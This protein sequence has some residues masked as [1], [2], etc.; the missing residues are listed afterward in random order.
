MGQ[1]PSVVGLTFAAVG[2][3]AAVAIALYVGIGRHVTVPAAGPAGTAQPHD[4]PD[5]AA[6]WLAEAAQRRRNHDYAG[7]KDAYSKVI[8]LN[9]MTAD[10]WADYAD[11]LASLGGGSFGDDARQAIQHALEL[12]P[13]HPKALWLEASRAYQQHRYSDAVTFWKRLRSALPPDSPDAGVV[14]ANIAESSQ[15]AGAAS[16]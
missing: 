13:R 5:S 15:L 7:A 6:R 14:D 3:F 10:S 11:A 9:A 8:R 4:D 16:N 1:G 12:E 2:V